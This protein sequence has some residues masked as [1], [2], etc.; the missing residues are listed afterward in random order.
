MSSLSNIVMRDDTKGNEAD[1][2]SLEFSSNMDA[3]L[4]H[5]IHRKRAAQWARNLRFLTFDNGEIDLG[6]ENPKNF[7]QGQCTRCQLRIPPLAGHIC[8]THASGHRPN[9]KS[10]EK[11]LKEYADPCVHVKEASCK[12][13]L[14]IPLFPSHGKITRFRIRRLKP[15]NTKPSGLSSCCHFVAV[16]YCWSRQSAEKVAETKSDDELYQVLEE[17]L[18][19][20][21]PIRAPK[22]TIDRAVSF[23][24]QNGI[25]MIWIDQVKY[26]RFIYTRSSHLPDIP[27]KECIEQDNEHEKEL[28]IQ[29]MDYVYLRADFSIGL[30]QATMQ[31]RHLDALL[32]SY[33]WRIGE[34]MRRRGPRP[35]KQC[36]SVRLKTLVEALRL[37]LEDRWNTRA[38]V[39]QEAFVSSGNMILLFPRA[40]GVIVKGWSLICHDLSLTEIGIKLDLLQMCFEESGAIVTSWHGTKTWNNFLKREELSERLRWFQP[41]TRHSHG[42]E[43]WTDASKPRQMCNAAVAVSFLKHRDNHRVADRLAII[44]NLC[45]YSI[46]LNTVNLERSQDRLSVCIFTLAII[47]GDFSLMA[48][49]FYCIPRGLNIRKFDQ[50]Q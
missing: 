3:I 7:C 5:R 34:N 10:H 20:V 13:C 33:E 19:T 23:A 27:P 35:L 14:H 28:G 22:D 29:A 11:R 41:K 47:N 4:E 12:D 40:K 37:V 48:P 39:L 42:I 26:L 46:R 16:S 8:S 9:V 31:Q 2:H 15:K 45:N 36:R 50:I 24:A 32:L 6:V 21:R 30:F 49:E 17:N 1:M 38:W 44:A 25:R 43:F 18:K